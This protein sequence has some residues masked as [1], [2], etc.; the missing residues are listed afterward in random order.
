MSNPFHAK[1]FMRS[2]FS[3]KEARTLNNCRKIREQLHD[4]VTAQTDENT[5]LEIEKH[6]QVCDECRRLYEA[7]KIYCGNLSHLSDHLTLPPETIKNAVV[8]RINKENIRPAGLKKR[9]MPI[10]SYG[11]AAAVVLA[12]ALLIF[13]YRNGLTAQYMADTSNGFAVEDA[14]DDSQNAAV[15]P[16]SDIGTDTVQG[17]NMLYSMKSVVPDSAA[18][19]AQADDASAPAQSISDQNNA[20]EDGQNS[21]PTDTLTTDADE[22]VTPEKAFDDSPL[23]LRTSRMLM[24]MPLTPC[25]SLCESAEAAANDT[26]AQATES[27]KNTTVSSK[28]EIPPAEHVAPPSN[29]EAYSSISTGSSTTTDNDTTTEQPVSSSVTAECDT[30]ANETI[31]TGDSTATSA[32][33]TEQPTSDEATAESPHEAPFM[34]TAK[35]P[36]GAIVDYGKFL[37]QNSLSPESPQV[38]LNN[39]QDGALYSDKYPLPLPVIESSNFYVLDITPNELKS[40]LESCGITD[41]IVLSPDSPADSVYL[42]FNN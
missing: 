28:T 2:I 42:F 35:T 29:T 16:E 15:N 19:N 23:I 14:A 18:Q 38:I 8:T 12:M 26:A 32:N 22:S 21:A 7:E 41:Y 11:T 13:S 4:Y 36:T 17:G 3:R 34:V 20:L 27:H 30:P 25:G 33:I 37:A 1:Q 10:F 9:R 5:S 24:S 40:R 6:L 39:A 31:P